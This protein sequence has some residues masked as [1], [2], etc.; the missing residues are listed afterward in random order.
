MATTTFDWK[1]KEFLDKKERFKGSPYIL[2]ILNQP[3]K[4][5]DDIFH[6]LWENAHLRIC[7]DGGANQLYDT[8]KGIYIPNYIRGDLDS[9]RD[10]VRKFYYSQ[11]TDIQ[12]EPEQ[13]STDFMKCINLVS[14]K[15][16]ENSLKYDVIA[17]GAFGGRFD[18]TMSN[19]HYLYKLKDER[20]IY[21]ISDKNLA[22]LLDK[23]K[24]NI[25]CDREIE[26]PTCGILPIG[27]QR[28]ILTTS[29]LKWNMTNVTSSFG[30]MISTSNIL[31][32]DVV[33]IETDTPV[34]WTVELQI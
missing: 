29:G 1:I 22:F 31:I 3:I 10:D 6:I 23:G 19:I 25:I 17:I 5:R 16:E 9:L 15:E 30:V 28:A 32:N 21:L 14:F 18:Q 27:V 26:G 33:T 24:H 13:E 8:F 11:G 12:H 7:A 2:I 20:K 34:I 4:C